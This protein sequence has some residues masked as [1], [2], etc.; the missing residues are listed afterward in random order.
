M[1]GGDAALR[2]L[3]DA[4]HARGMRVVLD[5]VFNHASR[6]FFQFHDILENGAESAYLDWFTSTPTC[7]PVTACSTP[8]RPLDDARRGFSLGYKAWWGLPALPKFNTDHPEVREYLCRR[9]RELDRFGI[10]GWRLDVPNEI[11]DD[12]VLG[13]VPPALPRDPTRCVHRRRG[14]GGRAGVAR[15]ATGWTR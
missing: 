13:G 12:V 11:D 9:R 3:L 5:G 2:E 1:L 4:A 8:T 10:D 15:G 6:G 7:W 14:L